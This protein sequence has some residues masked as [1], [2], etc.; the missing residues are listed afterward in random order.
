MNNKIAVLIIFFLNLSVPIASNLEHSCDHDQFGHRRLSIKKPELKIDKTIYDYTDYFKK[1]SMAAQE[2]R[3]SIIISGALENEQ[4][5]NKKIRPFIKEYIN[6]NSISDTQLLE[7]IKVAFPTSKSKNQKMILKKLEDMAEGIKKKIE[8]SSNNIASFGF[9]FFDKDN[10]QI[11]EEPY[12]FSPKNDI[13]KQFFFFSGRCQREYSET[14]DPNPWVALSDEAP[15]QNDIQ[16]LPKTT[17]YELDFNSHNQLKLSLEKHADWKNINRLKQI[18]DL[19]YENYSQSIQEALKKKAEQQPFFNYVYERFNRRV[20]KRE[21][22]KNLLN[23]LKLS[24]VDIGGFHYPTQKREGESAE[25]EFTH[26]EQYALF[27]I[28]NYLEKFLVKCTDKIK[29]ENKGSI[30]EI[31][32]YGVLI[33]TYNIMCVRCAQS[34]IIDF[35]HTGGNK[36]KDPYESFSKT[37]SKHF[38]IKD[39]SNDVDEYPMIFIAGYSQP[40][41]ESKLDENFPKDLFEKKVACNQE[42]ITFGDSFLKN[43]KYNINEDEQVTLQNYPEFIYHTHINL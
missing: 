34:L 42:N 33:Y 2:L 18:L 13:D 19:S 12:H 32:G 7:I 30:P 40:L 20:I 38:S 27:E 16:L 15:K 21:V 8:S 9:V 23:L 37:I 22:C 24:V 43:T 39:D 36:P 3:K 10:N 35:T 28:S 31:K 25:G 29:L 6:T 17:L 41:Y 4:E 5:E 11:N 26:S 14:L 1:V